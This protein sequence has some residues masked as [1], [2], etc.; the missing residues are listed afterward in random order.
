[1]QQ[2]Q[3]GSP[4]QKTLAVLFLAIFVL[5]LAGALAKVYQDRSDNNEKKAT[6]APFATPT[7]SP[8]SLSGIVLATRD[9]PAGTVIT[10]EM[11]TLGFWKIADL[12]EGYQKNI[13]DVL[14]KTAKEDIHF[15]DP[16]LSQAL[17]SS[18][19]N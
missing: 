2:P 15:Q 7:D 19:P 1:M 3:S 12:P 17:E 18:P 14:G 5:L 10:L 8:L 6:E 11:V 4:L 13:I 16:V 9:I